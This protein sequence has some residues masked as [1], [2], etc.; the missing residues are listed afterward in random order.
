MKNDLITVKSKKYDGSLHRSWECELVSFDGE[1]VECRGIFTDTI[2]HGELG[3]IKAGTISHE[4][5]W[6]TRWYNVF[7]FEEETGDLRNYYVNISM[8]PTFNGTTIEFVDLDIDVVIWPDGRAITLDR[9]EFEQNRLRFGYATEIVNK[10]LQTL[11]EILV[12][13]DRHII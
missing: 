7:R 3:L 6:L 4:K 8:P 1:V 13:T 11:N 10:A 2:K 5:F 9:E 12:D